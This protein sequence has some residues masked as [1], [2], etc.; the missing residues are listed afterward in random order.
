[1]DERFRGQCFTCQHWQG[2]RKAQAKDIKNN[3][4]CMNRKRGWPKEGP[5]TK[6]SEFLEIDISGNASVSLDFDA[7]F[8]CVY[9]MPI[10]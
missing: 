10:S 2:D 5:C 3:P 4:A 6:S 7:N 8:G 1:M 9:Y